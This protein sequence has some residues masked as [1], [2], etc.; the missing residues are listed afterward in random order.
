MEDVIN[1]M[2]TRMGLASGAAVSEEE[3]AGRSDQHGAQQASRAGGGIGDDFPH[4][5]DM[6]TEILELA[7]N[8]DATNA[9]AGCWT[10]TTCSTGSWS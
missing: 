2:R 7:E 9:S 6:Q 1:L 4:L 3:H 8:Y 10:T 5:G